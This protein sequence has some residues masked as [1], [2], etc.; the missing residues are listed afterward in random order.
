M[1]R[2][3]YPGVTGSLGWHFGVHRM[4]ERA[5]L[6]GGKLSVWSA[7]DSGTEIERSTPAARAYAQS[8]GSR[9]TCFDKELADKSAGTTHE[10]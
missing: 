5:K 3:G 2:S 10:Q 8:L 1:D 4:H 7:R 9:A 6:I